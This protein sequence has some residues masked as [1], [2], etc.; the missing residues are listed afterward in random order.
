[1][2]NVTC[3]FHVD[4]SQGPGHNILSK[5]IKDL[6]FSNNTMRGNED[7]HKECTDPMKDV[8][9]INLPYFT[10]GFNMKGFER[11]HFG[12]SSTYC[13]P[14]IIQIEYVMLIIK[15]PTYVRLP[16]K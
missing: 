2:K 15:P 4:D 9:N 16:Q 12:K 5:H 11:K 8:S 13:M 14:Q 1:M 10:I 6:C 7:I 3:N